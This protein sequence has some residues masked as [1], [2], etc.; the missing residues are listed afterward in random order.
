MNWMT[1]AA[2]LF[3]IGSLLPSCALGSDTELKD[4]TSLQEL[5]E[6]FENDSGNVRI[7]A[8]LSPT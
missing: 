1:A 6:V 7:L 5:R 2:F 8:L 3:L 4:L